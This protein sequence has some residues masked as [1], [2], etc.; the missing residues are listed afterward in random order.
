MGERVT[1]L[2]Q[3]SQTLS[4][5]GQWVGYGHGGARFATLIIGVSRQKG[6]TSFAGVG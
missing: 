4:E 2:K 1:V 6:L 5:P 3:E